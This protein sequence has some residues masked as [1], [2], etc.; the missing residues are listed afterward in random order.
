MTIELTERHPEISSSGVIVSSSGSLELVVD[1]CQLNQQPSGKQGK[2]VQ[3]VTHVANRESGL[4]FARSMVPERPFRKTAVCFWVKA[5]VGRLSFRIGIP[6]RICHGLTALN[7][8][9]SITAL[10]SRFL[11]P[12]VA[13]YAGRK[14]M[15]IARLGGSVLGANQR[16]EAS[17]NLQGVVGRRLGTCSYQSGILTEFDLLPDGGGFFRADCR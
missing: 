3:S 5:P 17:S 15:Q 10:V 7:N 12:R 11:L 14:S 8:A 1:D 9:T 13:L 2:N 4:G 6:L 16:F